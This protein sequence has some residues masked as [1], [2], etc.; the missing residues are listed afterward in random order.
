ML[1]FFINEWEVDLFQLQTKM[2]N[3]PHF[4]Y[5]IHLHFSQIKQKSQHESQCVW[6]RVGFK[7]KYQSVLYALL[8]ALTL[9]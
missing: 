5:T 4:L 1:V 8:L 3:V 9:Q 6:V 2:L 7:Y